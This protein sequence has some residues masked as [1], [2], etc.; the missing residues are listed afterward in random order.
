MENGEWRMEN[1]GMRQDV[2]WGLRGGVPAAAEGE[3]AEAR[4]S[5]MGEAALRALEAE[6]RMLAYA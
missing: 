3:R 5:D 2:S 6:E 1:G 4:R